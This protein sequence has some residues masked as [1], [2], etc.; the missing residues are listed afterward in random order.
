MT[1]SKINYN[2]PKYEDPME[3]IYAIRRELSEQY[4]HD[5][6]RIFE[7]ARESQRQAE[8]AGIKFV[9]LPIARTAP[10]MA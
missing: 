8:A 4:G 5:I 6:H 10:A 1:N 7:A 9:R 3:E 2:D